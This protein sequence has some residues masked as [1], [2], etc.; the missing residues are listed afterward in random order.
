MRTLLVLSLLLGAS[1]VA[2]QPP[3]DTRL[4]GATQRALD[5]QAT[6]AANAA[7]PGDENLSCEALQTEMVSIAQA[8]RQQPSLQGFAAQAQTDLAAAQE[9]QQAAEEQTARARPRFGQ[10]LRGF[11]TGVVPGADRAAAAAQQATAIAQAEEAQRQTNQNL[12]R[13][14]G[15]AD[16]AAAAAGPTMRGERVLELARARDCAWLKEGGVPPPG[17]FP[18]GAVPPASR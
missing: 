4:E 16:G 12:E 10:A 6:A 9:A 5:A 18:P 1:T 8:I 7:R 14:A 13:I 15:I 11:A 3:T 2:A 17:A